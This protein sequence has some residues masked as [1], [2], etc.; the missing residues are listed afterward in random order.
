M[1][2]DYHFFNVPLP[3]QAFIFF[4]ISVIL[5]LP[6][7]LTKYRNLLYNILLVFGLYSLAFCFI[8]IGR[9]IG[10]LDEKDRKAEN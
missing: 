9:Y 4:I 5:C 10:E 8:S 2:S 7:I 6:F 1:D 3:L